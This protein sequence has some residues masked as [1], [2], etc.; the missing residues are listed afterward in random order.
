MNIQS[1]RRKPYEISG[2]DNAACGS[3]HSLAGGTLVSPTEKSSMFDEDTHRPWPAANENPS[4]VMLDPLP[5]Q[6]IARY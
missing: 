2:R 6:E 3:L 5:R 1:K 4:Q